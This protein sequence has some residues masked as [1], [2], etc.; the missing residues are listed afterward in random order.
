MEEFYKKYV[1]AKYL[2]SDYGGE[3]SSMEKLHN[4]TMEKMER[5]QSFFDEEERNRKVFRS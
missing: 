3:L 4:M 5:R 2:P 1:P